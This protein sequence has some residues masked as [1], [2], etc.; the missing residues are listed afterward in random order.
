MSSSEKDR[1]AAEA[2]ECRADFQERL[3]SEKRNYPVH[4]FRAFWAITKRCAE[5]TRSD[6]LIHRCVAGAVNG[7]FDFLRAERER[8]PGDVP[9]DAEP[10]E[11]VLFLLSF[12]LLSFFLDT[13]RISRGMNQP[14]CKDRAVWFITHFEPR[15]GLVDEIL[16]RA[17]SARPFGL[18][19]VEGSPVTRA[20]TQSCSAKIARQANSSAPASIR[21]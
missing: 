10:V 4:Q 15:T 2:I 16:D 11:W 9:R 7:L 8:V 19:I 5:L 14:D 13:T 21:L 3:S 20:I 6:R 12:F 1:R 17:G 18:Q